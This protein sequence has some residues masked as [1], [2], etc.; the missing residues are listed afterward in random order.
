MSTQAATAPARQS[1]VGIAFILVGV[2][3]I[4]VNDMLIKQ[5]SAGYPLHQMVFTRSLIGIAFSL[6]LVQM[7]G[8]VTILRTRRPLLHLFRGLV[9]VISNLTFFTA[10]AVVPLAEA[11]ALFFVAPLM[12]TLLAVPLLGE[13]I[14]AYRLGAVGF[15][16]VG[17]V[18]M[19]RPWDRGGETGAGL[20][21][22]LL[23]VLAA[24]TYA[25]YQILTRKL[26]ASTK[27]SAMAVY[28]QAIFIL[29][30]LGF[31]L[32]AGDG[33]FADGS[34]NES[35]RFLLRAWVWPQGAD[36][37][38]FL[39]LGLNSAIV[40]YSLSQAYRLADAATIAPFE[41]VGL[42]LA[43]MW[44]WL[45]WG[46]IPG[47]VVTAGIVLIMGSGLFVFLREHIRNRRLVSAQ[48]VHRRY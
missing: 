1:A 10:L 16:F 19:L 14:G 18:V 44:G 3:A 12:I 35:V 36:I 40:A 47:A 7:E 23:P 43:V 37:W 17:V 39:G 32:V 22:L 45:I 25:L 41:Y 33:R 5:L 29:V 24:F 28:I 21:T 2:S 4:S 11:T 6:L 46:E 42:P 38:L 8:G 13:R 26:G 48:R 27:A 9:I 30:S 20:L 31:F 15:G 34:G